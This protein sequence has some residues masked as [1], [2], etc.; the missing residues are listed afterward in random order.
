MFRHWNELPREVV[1][2]SS[3]EVFR[4]CGYDSKG[5]GLVMGLSRSGCWLDTVTL[6]V[7]SSLDDSVNSVVCLLDRQQA[8]ASAVTR[9]PSPV[10]KCVGKAF[11]F[12]LC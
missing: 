8:R 6:R 5:D 1:E 12:Q 4:M 2:S 11:S 3:L 9:Q 10:A 7:F